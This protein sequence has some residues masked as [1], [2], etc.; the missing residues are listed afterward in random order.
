MKLIRIKSQRDGYRRAGMAHTRQGRTFPATAFTPAQV[1]QLQSDPRLLVEL[2]EDET[3]PGGSGVSDEQRYEPSPSAEAASQTSLAETHSEQED[4]AS[5]TIESA[6]VGG[7]VT[8]EA[9]SEAT[10]AATD[11]TGKKGSGGR[12][13]RSSK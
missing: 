6:D 3:V 8:P 12:S 4:A 10:D 9:A 7:A 5:E 1:S 13:S 11:S 2:F